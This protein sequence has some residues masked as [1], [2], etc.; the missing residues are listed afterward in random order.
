MLRDLI[1]WARRDRR[2]ALLLAGNF[3]A[4]LLLVVVV[5]IAFTPPA[6]PAPNPVLVRS[7]Q[8]V[9]ASGA[10]IVAPT[11]TAEPSVSPLPPTVNPTQLAQLPNQGRSDAPPPPAAPVQS[12]PTPAAT[13][14]PI[15]LPTKTAITSAKAVPPPSPTAKKR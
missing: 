4:V 11:P 14:T 13:L 5:V 10:V 3:A 15:A 9:T 1:K 12:L 8:T 6:R 7:A 2:V